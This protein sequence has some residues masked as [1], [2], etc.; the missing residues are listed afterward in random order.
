M[1]SLNEPFDMNDVFFLPKKINLLHFTILYLF[2]FYCKQHSLEFKTKSLVNLYKIFI[3]CRVPLLCHLYIHSTLNMCFFSFSL[4]STSESCHRH[5]IV[6][7]STYFDFYAQHKVNSPS[8]HFMCELAWLT[9]TP[10]SQLYF[11]SFYETA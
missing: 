3:E 1:K 9:I 11:S 4:A 10:P 6:Q 8:L 5:I 2:Y 7:H